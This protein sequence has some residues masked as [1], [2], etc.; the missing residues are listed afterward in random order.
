M[1]QGPILH[2]V[3]HATNVA[4]IYRAVENSTANGLVVRNGTKDCLH[5][6]SDGQNITMRKTDLNEPYCSGYFEAVPSVPAVPIVQESNCV[7]HMRYSWAQDNHDDGQPS[8]GWF[9]NF[10]G[11]NFQ[12]LYCEELNVGQGDIPMHDFTR[13]TF[14]T[15]VNHGS[16]MHNGTLNFNAGFGSYGL[17]AVG[18]LVIDHIWLE[19]DY[20]VTDPFPS[21]PIYTAK[22]PLRQRQ[23]SAKGGPL[24]RR[25]DGA[26]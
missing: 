20:S 11:S 12:D 8:I 22:P 23:S 9:F 17:N 10:D 25:Q 1:T 3:A 14:G 4:G 26:R 2:Y 21:T 5:D 7:L 18:W 19:F 24:R 16:S 15:L 6:S 13:N